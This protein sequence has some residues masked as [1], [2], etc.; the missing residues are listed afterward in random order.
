MI[1]RQLPG[2][3]IHHRLK[4]DRLTIRTGP[5]VV[6]VR[7]PIRPLAVAIAALY[8]DFP[9]VDDCQ[10]ADFHIEV[11]PGGGWLGRLRRQAV[12]TSGSWSR[13]DPFSRRLS[14]AFFEWGLNGCI[15]SSVN[16]YLVM[17]GAVV[18]RG[19]SGLVLLG[20][21]GSGKST[22]CAALVCAG[23]RLLSDELTLLV[24]G[25]TTLVPLAR[26]ISLKNE[27]ITLVRAM[28]PDAAFGPSAVTARKGLLAH[29]RPPRDSVERMDEPAQLRR[30]AF[31]RREANAAPSWQR[32]SPATALTAVARQSFNYGT[33]GPSG[34]AHLARLVDEC[35]CGTLIYGEVDDA[36]RLIE[37]GDF[38]DAG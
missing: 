14:T 36:V 19:G 37:R 11:A 2:E 34:F 28:A 31:V 26:P 7:T 10:F 32:M 22:L 33:R 25:S 5:F 12:F 24:P 35:P 20:P 8:A 9:I 30:I 3:E 4:R 21:S 29:M 23:W 13:N 18:E 17:H 16:H 27:S 1:L 38:A 15:F 6:S